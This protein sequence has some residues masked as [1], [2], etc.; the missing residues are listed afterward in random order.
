MD[1]TKR[2]YRIEQLLRRHETVG[3]QILVEALEVSRAT[4]KRDLQYLRDRFQWE[5]RWDRQSHGYRLEEGRSLPAPRFSARE[6]QALLTLEQLL[7]EIQPGLLGPATQALRSRLREFLNEDEKYAEA[8]FRKRLRI[9]QPAAR[10]GEPSH[11]AVISSATLSRKCLRLR[12]RNRTSGE[13][14]SR[15]VSPQ[16]LTLYKGTWYLEAWCHDTEAVR[17]FALDAVMSAG[18]EEGSCR[19]VSTKELDEVLGAGYGIFAG[20]AKREAVLR[21]SA[22]IAPWVEQERWHP[23]QTQQVDGENRLEVRVPYG[24]DT[25]LIMDLLRYGPDVEVLGPAE[26]RLKVRERLEETILRYLDE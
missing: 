22:R 21:F 4:V 8:V 24:E 1:R 11:F 13:V 19:E 26:L 16:R 12:H 17:R 14:K 7:A 3:V 18:V 25:E 9:V 10:P 15:R 23:Q 2:F 5:I 20:T 6:I